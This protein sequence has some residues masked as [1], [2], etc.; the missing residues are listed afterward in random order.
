MWTY[1]GIISYSRDRETNESTLW[2]N[3]GG[4]E[5]NSQ[6]LS[7]LMSKENFIK[8]WYSSNRLGQYEFRWT[9]N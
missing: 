5:V 9:N 2:I 4:L 1:P 3:T 7:I 8:D 6:L